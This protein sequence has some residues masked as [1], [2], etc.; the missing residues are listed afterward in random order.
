[1][2][3]DRNRFTVLLIALTGV[4]LALQ[5][6]WAN[7]PNLLAWWSFDADVEEGILIT[8]VTGNGY[9]ALRSGGTTLVADGV[10]NQA[11]LFDGVNGYLYVEQGVVEGRDVGNFATDDFTVSFWIKTTAT[12]FEGIMGKR[13][14]CSGAHSFWDLRLFNDLTVE[15]YQDNNINN[16]N[17]FSGLRILNDGIW[18]QVVLT[19]QSQMAAL[20]VDGKLDRSNTPELVVNVLNAAEFWMGRSRCTGLDGTSYFTGLLDEI[21]VYD[22]ALTCDQVRADFETMF[23]VVDLNRDTLIDLADLMVLTTEWL[24]EGA[25]SPLNPISPADIAPNCGDGIVNLF[26]FNLLALHWLE[27]I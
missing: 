7:D 5:P 2:K 18:H 8:D 4:L 11:M 21:R 10:V 9:D 3:L 25:F 24:E 16:G 15:L 1:M 23:A 17:V 26:D 12:R 14:H 19:R 6:A 27:T 13:V 22:R 20:Y